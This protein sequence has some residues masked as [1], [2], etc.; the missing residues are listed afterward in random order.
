MSTAAL[1]IRYNRT[2]ADSPPTFRRRWT[3][4]NLRALMLIVVVIAIP[5][6]WT[7]NRVRNRRIVVAAIQDMNGHI[8]YDY[9]R[10]FN[11]GLSTSASPLGS[12]WLR[13]VFGEHVFAEIVHVNVEG[14]K[15]TDE[16]LALISSLPHLQ[17]LGVRSDRITDKGVATIA[18][19]K[20]LQSLT[21]RST[22][23]TKAS[24]DYLQALPELE[25]LRCSGK[26]VN[27]SWIEHFGKLASLKTLVLNDTQITDEGLAALAKL[28]NLDGL[29]FEDMPITDA[30][31]DRLHRM[32]NLTRIGLHQTQITASGVQ[33]LNT[34]L[35]N[36]KVRQY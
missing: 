24:I 13:A 2:M 30:S 31:L 19:S 23:V 3:R 18:E 21:L 25:F 9:Q 33:R 7:V 6:G 36:C 10:N 14:P 20:E 12:K 17:L 1:G 29:F 34:A 11:V 16:S 4:F 8:Y 15:V 32:S 28:K 27:D 5:L 26:H 35:P 22:N